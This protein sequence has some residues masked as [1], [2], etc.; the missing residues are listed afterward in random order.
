M[1]NLVL[2]AVLGNE[3]IAG[4]ECFIN[5][6]KKTFSINDVM[7]T[8]PLCKMRVVPIMVDASET[9]TEPLGNQMIENTNKQFDPAEENE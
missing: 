5:S 2:D 3:F 6:S 8:V 9:A 7:V 1:R 4:H